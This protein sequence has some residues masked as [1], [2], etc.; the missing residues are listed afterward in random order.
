MTLP[1]K[2]QERLE[3]V[4]A[5]IA[6]QAKRAERDPNDIALIAVSKTKPEAAIRP[7]LEAGHRLFGENRVQEAQ[8][9]WPA[10][11]VDYPDLCL[12]LIGP[13]QSNKA[14]DAVRLFDR[15]DSVDRLKI[16]RTL[17]RVM[18]E[19]KRHLP[20]LIQVNT[21]GEA[22]KAGILPEEADDFIAQC[23]DDLGLN[24]LGLQC[25]PPVDD[26]PAPHFALLRQIAQR[27]DLKELSM[28]MSADY[29][30]GIALGAT[31]VRVGTAL[32]GA[33]N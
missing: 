30:A 26:H 23:R 7:L 17:S 28:G 12:A 3:T 5:D 31:F 29:P 20:V 13:L 25:I 19:E 6:R 11:K 1:V 24:V 10:L 32:F 4:L 21:G 9:K 18:D 22:Q 2:P 16:A 8:D 27:N 15:I 33:R 14:R